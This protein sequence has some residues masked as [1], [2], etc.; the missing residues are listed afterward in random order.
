MSNE[1][2]V[3]TSGEGSK[4]TNLAFGL[5]SFPPLLLTVLDNWN[6]LTK[7]RDFVLKEPPREVAGR[8]TLSTGL[9]PCPSSFL[10][11]IPERKRE[12]LRRKRGGEERDGKEREN[13]H[14]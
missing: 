3:H 6:M 2:S 14:E 1:P 4:H 9:N 10:W 12:G 11:W 7:D 13:G 8:L 5:L